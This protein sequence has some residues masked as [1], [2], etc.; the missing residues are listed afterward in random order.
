MKSH[1][2][3]EFYTQIHLVPKCDSIK[4]TTVNNMEIV[5]RKN[6]NSQRL[7]SVRPKMIPLTFLKLFKKEDKNNAFEIT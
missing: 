1:T 2:F 7:E 3:K 6:R 5:L 4:S